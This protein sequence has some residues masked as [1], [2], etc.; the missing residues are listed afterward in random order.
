ME[1]ELAEEHV[2]VL[3]ERLKVDEIRQRAMDRRVGAFG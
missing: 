3:D 2:F 1:I